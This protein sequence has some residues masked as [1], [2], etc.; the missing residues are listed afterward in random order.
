MDKETSNSA[1]DKSSR[2]KVKEVK[3]PS[4]WE[5]LSFEDWVALFKETK[6]QVY[7]YSFTNHLYHIQYQNYPG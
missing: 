6:T 2:K 5:A 7:E 3:M 4:N 1:L